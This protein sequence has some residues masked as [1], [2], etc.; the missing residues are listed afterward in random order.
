MLL[1]GVNHIAVLTA[2]TDRLHGF[3]RDVFDA[4]VFADQTD[5]DMRLSFVDIGPTTR[6]NVF[7]I[8]GN[9]QPQVQT[10]MFG[11][12]RIDHFGL[13]AASREAFDI[14]RDRLIDHGASDGFVSDFGIGYGVFFRDPDGLEGEVNLHF[15]DATPADIKPPGVPAHDYEPIPTG[16]ADSSSAD[17]PLPAD[18]HDR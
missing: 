10:P 8:A 12:G 6:L 13:E 3:Y 5:G 16:A 18:D 9:T 4:T 11:R 2:D 7:E 14:I 17:Q 15:A 1:A